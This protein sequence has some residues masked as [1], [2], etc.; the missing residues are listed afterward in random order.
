MKN[1]WPPPFH[2]PTQ[3]QA[4][5]NDAKINRSRKMVLLASYVRRRYTEQ[6]SCRRWYFTT[7]THYTY[8]SLNFGW[9]AYVEYLFWWHIEFDQMVSWYIWWRGF[10]I[11][12][13]AAYVEYFSCWYIEF[14]QMVSWYIWWRRVWHKFRQGSLCWIFLL[15]IYWIQSDG[16][17]IYLVNEGLA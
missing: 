7:L 17:M 3:F 10:G 1:R 12:V 5:V 8:R 6:G 4:T 14:N 9:A 15:L 16:V 2:K 11:N 13:W